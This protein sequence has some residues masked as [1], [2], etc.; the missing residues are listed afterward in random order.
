MLPRHSLY[1]EFGISKRLERFTPPPSQPPRGR[2]V[3]ERFFDI[4]FSQEKNHRSAEAA[5]SDVAK[6]LTQ[7]WM[8]GD[9][10]I[11]LNE[12]RTI[13]KKILGF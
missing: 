2:E 3:L 6:E 10:R 1:P 12:I 8:L 13:T 4:L 9:A 11:P 5:A 7:L